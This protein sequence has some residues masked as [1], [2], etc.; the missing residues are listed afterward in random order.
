MTC[1]RDQSGQCLQGEERGSLGAEWCNVNSEANINYII[2]IICVSLIQRVFL[3][4]T[5]YMCI[6]Y[7]Y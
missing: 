2:N 6:C 5:L 3:E 7:R 1:R 4:V